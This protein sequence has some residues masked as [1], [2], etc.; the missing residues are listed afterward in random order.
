MSILR[1]CVLFFTHDCVRFGGLLSPKKSKAGRREGQLVGIYIRILKQQPTVK[2]PHILN[3]MKTKP[4][5]ISV[6][7]Y[8]AIPDALAATQLTHVK[9]SPLHC[10]PVC[11]RFLDDSVG[12]CF[13]ERDGKFT[14]MKEIIEGHGHGH[15]KATTVNYRNHSDLNAKIPDEF[16][17]IPMPHIHRDET[18]VDRMEQLKKHHKDIS[19]FNDK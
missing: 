1:K 19:H 8:K 5:V 4:L 7:E 15:E 13:F 10:Q 2:M 14:H 12:V 9:D 11:V 6:S 3:I 18:L 16:H 17:R